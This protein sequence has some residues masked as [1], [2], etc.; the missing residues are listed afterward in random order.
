MD[1]TTP[2]ILAPAYP[3]APLPQRGTRDAAPSDQDFR[4]LMAQ[5]GLQ[6]PKTADDAR[7][8]AAQIA[9]KAEVRAGVARG[10]VVAGM[11]TTPAARIQAEPG[12]FMP[13]RQGKS[14]ARLYSGPSYSAAT[15]ESVRATQKFAPR[16]LA[17]PD[18]KEA[19]PAV[20]KSL[21]RAPRDVAE[22]PKA[23]E[24]YA[25][26]LRAASKDKPGDVPPWF[27][28]AMQDA[29]DKYKALKSAK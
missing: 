26:G 28:D 18:L 9:G 6:I 21:K 23:H 20:A 17:N 4:A 11:D 29:H 25:Y 7:V 2:L 24:A 5:Q 19:V 14:A 1:T 22:A 10:R 3:L 15:A 16:T 12:R 13:L 27:G 8:T